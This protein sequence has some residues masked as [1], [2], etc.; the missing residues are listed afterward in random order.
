MV[1]D[2]PIPVRFKTTLVEIS[3]RDYKGKDYFHLPIKSLDLDSYENSLK[4]SQE[5]CTVDG[6]IGICNEKM[7]KP[8]NSKLHFVE[9][10]IDC[11]SYRQLEINPLIK[12]Q[13][14]SLEIITSFDPLS[15][16][17]STLSIIYNPNFIQ[18]AINWLEQQKRANKKLA[19]WKAFTPESFLTTVN[20]RNA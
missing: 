13:K 6:V 15:S 4:K 10:K 1:D 3:K 12:K 17:D 16:V 9:L 19:G 8:V 11:E 14:R 2:F 20:A 5:E 7:G 18:R